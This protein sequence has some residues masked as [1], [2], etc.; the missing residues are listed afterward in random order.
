[1]ASASRENYWCTD[2]NKIASHGLATAKHGACSLMHISTV[3]EEYY[4]AR[5]WKEKMNMDRGGFGS[6]EYGTNFGFVFDGVTMGGKIN[7]YA[8]QAFANYTAQWLLTHSEQFKHGTGI[9]ILA[10]KLFEGCVGGRNNPVHMNRSM[11]GSGGAAT[12]L[13]VTIEKGTKDNL[14]LHGASVGDS[15]AFQVFRRGDEAYDAAR[16][17]TPECIRSNQGA[18]DSG[19]QMLLDIGIDG[20]IWAFSHPVKHEDL[21]ILCSDGLTDNLH[22]PESRTIMPLILTLEDFDKPIQFECQQTQGGRLPTFAEISVQFSSSKR[23]NLLDVTCE[24][25]AIRLGNYVK[26]I[27]RGRYNLE[28]EYFQLQ[29]DMQM[30]SEEQRRVSN[31]EPNNQELI[32]GSSFVDI[33]KFINQKRQKDLKDKNFIAGKTDDVI[34]VVFLP[35]DPNGGQSC[36]VS[37]TYDIHPDGSYL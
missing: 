10:R 2:I 32:M 36:K 17:L 34:I 4:I 28:K 24:M 19:G 18:S 15:A 26:W 16:L 35:T 20:R 13:F 9:D 31:G 33:D 11:D 6:T 5:Q 30:M 37:R 23:A 14:I 25:A 21:I 22:M 27:T 29:T 12:G 8:S 1:M 3:P 7:L